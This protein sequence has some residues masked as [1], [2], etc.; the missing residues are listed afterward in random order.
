[1][2]PEFHFADRAIKLTS[3]AIREILKVTEKKEI[4]S[5]AGGLP[6]PEGFPIEIVKDA[7]NKVLTENGKVALQYGTTEGYTPLRQW[8]ADEM[9]ASGSEINIDQILIVSG[10][11]QALDLL[12]KILINEGDKIL[13]ENPSYLGALQSFGLYQPKYIPVPTDDG[14]LIPEHIDKETASNA[15]FL[16]ALP[17]F[18]NP[19]GRTLSLERRKELVKLMANLNI[20]IIEDDPYGELRYKG[21]PQPSLLSLSKETGGTVI[22]LGTFSKVLAPGLRLGYVIAPVPIIR[23][24]VQAK[25]ASDL[26]TPTL[27]Q[28]AVYEV[29][30]DGFLQKH[31]PNVRDIYRTQVQCMLKALEKEF[32]AGIQWTKPEGGMFLWIT[33]PKHIDSTK[34]LE[35]AIVRNIAFV[36]G[37]PFFIAPSPEENC[38]MRLSFATVPEEKIVQ[39]ISLLGQLIKENL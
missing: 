35:K 34:L 28:M 13:V 9:N 31:L 10:S 8:I 36:T 39:G 18:Q 38:T 30:K 21:T 7:F 14:G 11:Q 16:Y 24:L 25:Q 4:I 29:I 23:K 15:R 33:L 37:K 12:G 5:F 1:M 6:S 20:P 26:H 2:K 19:T 32:P 3:S 22:R 17:N 27:T